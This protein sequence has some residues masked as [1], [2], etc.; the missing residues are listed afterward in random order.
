[1][2]NKSACPKSSSHLSVAALHE[3]QVAVQ[4]F[5]GLLGRLRQTQLQAQRRALGT[6]PSDVATY[7]LTGLNQLKP[8]CLVPASPKLT[9]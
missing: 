6:D 9:A 5:R 2:P 4:N 3:Y 7:A 8:E 1:M